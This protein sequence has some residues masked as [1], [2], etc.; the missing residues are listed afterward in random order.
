MTTNTFATTSV[1]TR[2]MQ[3]VRYSRLWWVGLLAIVLAVIANLIVRAVAL[4]FITV[5]PE[6]IP[7]SEPGATVVFTAVGVLA[8]TIVFAITGRVTR[9]PARVYTIVA[10]IALLL[11][12]VPNMSMLMN[13]ASAPFPGASLGSNIVLMLEHLVAAIVAVWVLT[14]Q[15]VE[16][17]PGT[18]L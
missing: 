8:A 9:Q 5:P 13:P 12:L 1:A 6:F 3:R 4:R 16:T 18:K 17:L 14:T 7:L 10:I 15:A 2:S 11:S